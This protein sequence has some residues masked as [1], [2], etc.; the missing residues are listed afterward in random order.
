MH[1]YIVIKSHESTYP[2]PIILQAQQ[3]VLYGAEDTEYPNWIFCKSLLT[4][5]EGWVPKQMLTTPDDSG[6]AK[7]LQ[8]YSA[9][10]LTVL[11]GEVLLGMKHLNAWTYC[12]TEKGELGWVPSTCLNTLL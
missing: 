3:E 1:R 4:D 12:K 2:D 6:I 8:D 9:H 5:K 11:E 10:E 7:V